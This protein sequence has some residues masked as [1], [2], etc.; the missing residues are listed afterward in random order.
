MAIYSLLLDII[1]LTMAGIGTVWVAFYLVKP[2][3]DKTERL[4]ILELKK[5][6]DSQTLPLRLQA[7]ER[8]VLF[9]ERCN[10]ASLLIRLGGTTLSATELYQVAA[11]EVREEF[12]H[13]LT[14]QIYVSSRAWV[15]TRR[16]KDDTL[17]LL[18]NTL[19]G[20]PAGATGLDFSR[21]V[22]TNLSQLEDNPYDL[23]TGLIHKDLD[24]LFN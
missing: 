6:A 11:N 19:Q 21:A 1:K 20:L 7:Y 12:Q 2:Y 13:N 16:L 17:N 10:P 4:R 18:N 9:I 15:V 22:L 3:L 24:E 23:A 5:A 8:L 14:Q